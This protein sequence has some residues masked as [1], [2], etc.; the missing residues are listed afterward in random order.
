MLKAIYKNI[1]KAKNHLLNGYPIIY[2]TDT[3][4]SFGAIAND[5]VT[6]KKINELKKR[7]SPISIIV[8]N[9]KKIEKYGHVH[10]KHKELINNIFPGK[11]TIL[12]KAKKHSLS[13]LIQNKSN[14]IGIRIPEELFC[15][16]LVSALSIPIITTSIN[17]HGNPPLTNVEI[18][19]KTYPKIQI[20]Y[21]KRNLDSKGSTILDLS[22]DQS[23]N[24]MRQGDGEIIT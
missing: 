12:L 4:Y 15:T 2:P 20:Y 7:T 16:K 23:I 13:K 24:T 6:I 18:I 22:D 19:K 1:D 10:S 3:L 8:S 11:Y 5:D 21:S 17:E 14:L 9:I